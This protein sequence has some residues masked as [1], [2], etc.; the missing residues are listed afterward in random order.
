[1]IAAPMLGLACGIAL[2]ATFP[3]HGA[4]L[5]LPWA[6][7][8]IGDATASGVVFAYG[9]GRWA[10]LSALHAVR[11][12]AVALPVTAIALGG[13]LLVYSTVLLPGA[14]HLS[15]RASVVDSLTVVGSVPAAFAMFG[16]RRVAREAVA[17]G[18]LWGGLLELLL[19]LRRMLQRLL[20]AVGVLLALTTFAAGTL[21][22]LEH[23]VHAAYGNRPPQ[24]VLVSGAVG[25]LLVAVVY[26][27][28]WTALQR[29]GQRLC[30]E[31]LPVR[32]LD[33]G[34]AIL[35]RATD[36]RALQQILGLDRGFFADLQAG[37]YIL[38]PLLAS[39]AAALLP[40]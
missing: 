24:F 7:F 16:I 1:M 14:S 4:P 31:L 23:S 8:A 38:A 10:E 11:A 5:F 34:A 35:S 40:H 21:L 13:L 6:A 2:A 37:L 3:E 28:A 29:R 19:A 18:G 39:A 12:R 9:L 15:P 27:P 36:H 30:D 33:Q 22:A 26:G 17:P 20:A 32:L 25:S